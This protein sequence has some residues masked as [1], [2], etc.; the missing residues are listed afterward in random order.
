MFNFE[1]FEFSE[2]NNK[3]IGDLKTQKVLNEK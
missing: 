1:Q 2:N 3:I